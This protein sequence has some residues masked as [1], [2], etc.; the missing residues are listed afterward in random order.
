MAKLG[1]GETV[2]QLRELL[3]LLF[4]RSSVQFPATTHWLTII[5]MGL[6][7]LFCHAGIHANRT[8]MYI[9]YINK[10]EC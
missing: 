1:A 9:K 10:G 8:L 7:V 6:N 2:Q 5:L 3:W 4:Q